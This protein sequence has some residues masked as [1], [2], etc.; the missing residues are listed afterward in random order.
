[1]PVVPFS[2]NPTAPQTQRPDDAFLMMAA[3]QMHSEGRLIATGPYGEPDY[4][5]KQPDLNDPEF[6]KKIEEMRERIQREHPRP[7]EKYWPSNGDRSGPS[8]MT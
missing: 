2:S 1:M 4:I 7:P 8:M 3:A 5:K 6:Q